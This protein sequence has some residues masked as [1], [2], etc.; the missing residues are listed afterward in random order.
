MMTHVYELEVV[1]TVEP[2]R[3]ILLCIPGTYCSPVVF[4][5]LDESA[6]PAVQLVPL[7]WM[8]SPGPWD[9]PALGR[10]VA[11]LILDLGATSV[12]LAGHSTG[13]AIALAAAAAAPERVSGLLLADTGAHMHGHGDVA[14]ILT[15]IERGP[16]PE[17]FQALMR[18]SFYHQPNAALIEQ[19]IAYASAAPREAALQAL[20]SQAALDLTDALPQLTMPA[21]VVHGRHDQARPLAHAEW[22]MQ[23]LP[24][25]EMVLLDCGH[26]PMVE[27]APAFAQ[28]VQRLC[29]LAGISL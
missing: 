19:M 28:A 4:E 29:S 21:V 16:G 27:M 2:G 22:L 9:I 14:S 8:T 5:G 25:A 7:S 13:G 24:R 10:R 15:V 3:P 26:T 6:F 12:L 18:R 23:H 17:F 11:Q 20:R 1:R